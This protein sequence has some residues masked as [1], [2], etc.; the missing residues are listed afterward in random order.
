MASKPPDHPR[1]LEGFDQRFGEAVLNVLAVGRVWPDPIDW[2]II[3][4][5]VSIAFGLP[6]IGHWLAILDLRAY[7][8]ALRGVLVR[9]SH[10]FPGMP[11]WARYN[12][13]GCLLALGLKLPCTEADVKRAYH[14]LAQV[15][16]PDRGGDRE[17]F[18]NLQRNFDNAIEFLRERGVEEFEAFRSHDGP[19]SPL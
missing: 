19:P 2:A 16:H 17:R 18:A 1:I 7:L 11:A 4:L 9:A 15:H 10:V 14:E 3:A 12:T 5:F 13:P 8:R 6:L